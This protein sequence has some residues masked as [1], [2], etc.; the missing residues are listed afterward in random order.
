[1]SGVTHRDCA[2]QAR[3]V[4]DLKA[5]LD[6]EMEQ[7]LGPERVATAKKLAVKLSRELKVLETMCAKCR[8]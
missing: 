6:R 1:M 3:L 8:A 2:G 5:Q 7:D 4:R